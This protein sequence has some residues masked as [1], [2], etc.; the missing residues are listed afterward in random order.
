[1]RAARDGLRRLG[2]HDKHDR[3]D[4]HGCRAPAHRHA[5]LPDRARGHH[6]CQGDKGLRRGGH[7][8]RRIGRAGRAVG[9]RGGREGGA[10]SEGIAGHRAGQLGQRHRPGHQQPGRHRQPRIAADRR[11]PAPSES[12]TGRAVGAELRRGCEVGHREIARRRRTGDRPGQSTAYAPHQ[13]EGVRHQFRHLVLRPQALQHGQ[14]HARWPPRPR[15]KAS[16]S[17]TPPPP[18]SWSRATAAK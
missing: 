4:H 10:A 5:Q 16:R 3:R 7:R 14:R 2:Q 6:R 17:S 11:Q 13:Q 9:L 18:S 1:M 12:R 8:R 15:R